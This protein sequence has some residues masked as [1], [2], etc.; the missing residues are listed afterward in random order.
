MSGWETLATAGVGTLVGGVLCGIVLVWAR[1]PKVLVTLAGWAIVLGFLAMLVG[2]VVGS[3]V[4]RDRCE[5]LDGIYLGDSCYEPPL[6][7][8]DLG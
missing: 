5:Q 3:H 4:A 7:E 6:R 8:I 2:E 1:A